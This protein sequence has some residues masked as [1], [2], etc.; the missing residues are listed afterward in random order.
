[1]KTSEFEAK[2]AG[3]ESIEGRGMK[4]DFVPWDIREPQP[5][6]VALEKAGGFGRR[7]L[8]AGCGRGENAMHL[9]G[10]GHTVTAFDSSPTAIAQARE[11]TRAH[12]VDVAFTVADVTG[13]DAVPGSFDTV[14]D[15]GLYH[16][17][18]EEVR[19]PYVTGLHGLTEPG[20]TWHL[21]CFSET[22]AA[23]LPMDWLR[24]GHDGLRATLDGCWRVAGIE[25]TTTTTTMTRDI[26]ERQRQA[27]AAKGRGFDADALDADERGRILMPISHLLVE[28]I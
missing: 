5:V 11:R 7:V 9:A 1:V 27:A 28:R 10:R 25:E 22:T 13:L 15:W 6:V 16:C 26:L 17:L 12:G 8:D 14:L 3:K 24:V 4:L 2:Y 19:R 21:F 18:P 23:S 20:A